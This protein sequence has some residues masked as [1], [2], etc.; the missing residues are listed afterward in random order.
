MTYYLTLEKKTENGEYVDIYPD[1]LEAFESGNEYL[2]EY[3][4]KLWL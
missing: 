1:L 4:A 3:Q 2:N